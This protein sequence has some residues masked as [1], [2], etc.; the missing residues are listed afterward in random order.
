MSGKSRRLGVCRSAAENGGQKS[1]GQQDYE[2]A[3]YLTG[4][5]TSRD[6]PLIFFCQPDHYRQAPI[7]CQSQS[8]FNKIGYSHF[9]LVFVFVKE[10]LGG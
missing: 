3:Y 7:S 8:T 2:N 4:E 10:Y 5:H 9:A 1:H 6:A